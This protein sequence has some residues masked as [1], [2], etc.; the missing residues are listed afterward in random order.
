[1]EEYPLDLSEF[2]AWFATEQ[3]CRD[4]LFRLRWQK[5]GASALGLQM[6]LG[7]G[8]TRPPGLGS[9]SYVER[10]SGPAAT[11]CRVG[12]R[13]TKRIWAAWRRECEAD[14]RSVSP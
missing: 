2:E 11:V 13:L 3:A 4:Y 12:S 9:T 5:N 8:A 10:W 7:L 14:R 6:V 1:M